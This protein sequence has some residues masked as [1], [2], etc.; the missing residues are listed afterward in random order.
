MREIAQHILDSQKAGEDLV[1]VT[2]VRR[3]GSTPRGVGSQMLISSEGLACGT[4]GGGPVE[5]RAIE[6]AKRLLQL[7]EG[8]VE[9]FA[10][11]YSRVE[12]LNMP[13]G[14]D[15]SLLYSFV[16]ATNQSWAEAMS[17][18]QERLDAR[19]MTYLLLGRPEGDCG[20]AEAGIALVGQSGELIAGDVSL[21]CSDFEQVE[22]GH[23]D[24]R[25][26]IMPLP[27][28]HRAIVFGAGHVAHALVP[29]L[30]GVGFACTVF[31]ARSEFATAER[32]PDARHIV[33]DSYEKASELLSLGPRDYVIIM[34]HS[35]QSDYLVLEQ[36]LRQSVAYVGFMGSKK[37]IATARMRALD[38]GISE[39]KLNAVHWPVGLDI[40]AE[41]PAEIAISVTAECVLHR[42]SLR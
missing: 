10:L 40:K 31:D 39:E 8:L 3:A 22:R 41:T 2:V 24:E 6:Q 20:L 42:A 7:G 29:V 27:L 11:N 28:P 18:A 4:I 33:C 30:S 12:G 5:A 17:A 15:V 9:D 36:V 13:C 38:A 37:K 14:G 26:F 21:V 32:F 19:Q 25:G 35:H 1:L 34:T 23:F 16:S